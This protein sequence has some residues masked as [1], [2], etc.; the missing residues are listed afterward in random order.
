MNVSELF[1]PCLRCTIARMAS[2]QR[3]F[4]VTSRRKANHYDVLG[5]GK[6]ASPEEIKVAYF[7]K[8]KRL[9]PDAKPNDPN[10][11][12]RFVEL[13]EAYAVIG[14][15]L[16]RRDYDLELAGI[17]VSP[18]R[19]RVYRAGTTT[20]NPY[21]SSEYTH[22]DFYGFTGAKKESPYYGVR[23]IKKTNNT[24]VLIGCLL[25]VS[26][27]AIIHF[28]LARYGGMFTRAKLDEKDR[29]IGEI[30]NQVKQRARQN[31]NKKQMELLR[32]NYIE[33]HAKR[34]KQLE[35]VKATKSES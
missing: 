14:K 21:G 1:T 24:N 12:N 29:R 32:R 20:S 4:S 25:L 15:P 13:N 33:M 26:G 34:Q 7:E 8:S 31:G 6:S 27:G 17:R 9:H 35:T 3:N 11:H 2:V 22:H 16:S 28:V 5:I 23:G 19:V 10:Q 30:Y 18:S